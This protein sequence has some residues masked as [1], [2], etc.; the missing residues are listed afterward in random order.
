MLENGQRRS[1]AYFGHLNDI[2]TNKN[3]EENHKKLPTKKMS[4]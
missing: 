2:T 3:P 4:D 1:S